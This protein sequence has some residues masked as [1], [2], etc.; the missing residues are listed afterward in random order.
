MS[1]FDPDFAQTKYVMGPYTVDEHDQKALC[2]SID[3]RGDNIYMLGFM[4]TAAPG[5]GDIENVEN[6]YDNRLLVFL[7]AYHS[8]N[9]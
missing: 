7:V 4:N 2:E 3:L 9:S 6:F 1:Q 8:D 5:G